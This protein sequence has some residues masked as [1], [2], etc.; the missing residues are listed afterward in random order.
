MGTAHYNDRQEFWFC[1]ITH[2]PGRHLQAQSIPPG[3][4][5]LPSPVISSVRTEA[6]RQTHKLVHQ[7]PH[8]DS[9]QKYLAVNF[10][11]GGAFWSLYIGWQAW[12][13]SLLLIMTCAVM[14]LP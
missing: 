4:H 7:E 9:F 14:L 10:V 6:A 8:G 5:E 3:V 2:I 12:P 13:L 1:A 11:P